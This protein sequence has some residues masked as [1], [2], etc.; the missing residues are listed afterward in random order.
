MIPENE[1]LENHRR[2]GERLDFYRGSGY[3]LEKE[4]ELIID[5]SLPFSGRILE[6]GT[7]KGHFTLALAKRGFYLTT[8]DISAEEQRT[9]RLN[10][11][12][13]GLEDRVAW[14]TEDAGGLSFPDGSFDVIFS[15]NVFHHLEQPAKALDEMSRVLRPAG[16]IILAD[17]NARGFEIINECHAKEGRVHD[18]SKHDLT[19]AKA[20]LESIG[21][22]VGG[23]ES[24]VQ[25]TIVARSR[26]S[27]GAL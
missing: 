8:V 15:V 25:R 6:I 19:E 2:Y 16:K 26:R 23:F 7:G 10:L 1:V 17:F 20:Y 12:Y 18:R 21:Y 13:Y 9:A 4:R 22:D 24:E 11:R 27:G 5:G 14:C 3:D